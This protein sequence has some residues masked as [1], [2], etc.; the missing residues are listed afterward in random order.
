MIRSNRLKDDKEIT[1]GF[2]AKQYIKNFVGRYDKEA[3]VPYYSY[4]DFKGLK[5]E[6]FTFSNSKN[7]EIHYF[8]YYYDNYQEDK[9]VLFLHGLACGHAAY[10]AEIEQLAKRGYKVLTLDYTGCGE[11]KGK[12]LGSVNTPTSDVVELLD[13]LKLD[14]EIVLVGHSMGGFTAINLINLRKE[15]HK[16]VVISGFLTI[17]L[18]IKGFIKS[19]FILNGVLRY[20]RKTYPNYYALDNIEYL[21]TT[22]DK[23]FFIH[24]DTDTM[25]PY[26]QSMKIV[27]EMNNPCIK[28]LL[29][30]DR[31]HNPNYTDAAVEYMNNT[32][33]IY[34]ELIRNKEIK[35]DEDKVNYFKDKPLAKLVEQDEEVF[36]QIKEFLNN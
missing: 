25:V 33:A 22:I 10:I 24:S 3:G 4:L 7:V 14:K 21:K 13:Y 2:I 6:A 27:E 16:A 18:E 31:K 9:I 12:Y 19:R 35:T 17:P 30:K 32:F 1:M 8:Y 26:A 5:Q 15:I 34:Y 28:T 29:I 36:D 20:E 11:S 23:L